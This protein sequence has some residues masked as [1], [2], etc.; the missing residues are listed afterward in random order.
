MNLIRPGLQELKEVRST[1]TVSAA[2]SRQLKQLHNELQVFL[3]TNLAPLESPVQT[4]FQDFYFTINGTE[5][6]TRFPEI[7]LST[8]VQFHDKL[9]ETTPQSEFDQLLIEFMHRIFVVIAAHE[10][11]NLM[12]SQTILYKDHLSYWSSMRMSTVSQ[13]IFGVQT[14][15]Q[16][17]A[18]LVSRAVEETVLGSS[19][20][21]FFRRL[22]QS[23][24]AVWQ[25]LCSMLKL[26]V[27]AL[28][29]NFVFRRSRL[30]WIR[31]PFTFI[32]RDIKHRIKTAQ[33][34]LDG[35]Y[36]KLGLLITSLPVDQGKLAAIVGSDNELSAVL[37]ASQP[38]RA[39]SAVPPPGFFTRNWPIIA[40]LVRFGPPTTTSVWQN[41]MAIV[42]W[43]RLNLVDT[44]VGFFKNW[45]VKPVWD[46]LGILRADDTMTITSKDSLRSD[47]E[48]LER[49]VMDFLR[50]NKVAATTEQV[51]Q[52]VS[53]GDL[54]MMMS[55]Y[56]NEIKTPYRL[57]V[58]GLMI[59]LLLIQIQKT[60]VD[61]ATAIS[62][63][64]KLLKLQQLLFGALSILPSLFI[65]YQANR[66][67]HRE[68]RDTEGKRLECLKSLSE[69][70]VLV[71]K[72]TAYD[73][74]N[75]L[76]R[77]FVGIVHLV[78][79]LRKAIPRGLRKEWLH[80]LNELMTVAVGNDDRAVRVLERIW[81][82]YAP[83]FR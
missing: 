23:A 66:A 33:K 76:G 78:L 8:V 28:D 34:Q 83:F 14:F 30:R 46:M 40:L 15:P 63:I 38:A 19:E 72:E 80:D 51:H 74:L 61:G 16:R 25:T 1:N 41:R 53:Q 6:L 57:L 69:I 59:R 32:D 49:M 50:D 39:H 5:K 12:I 64:D 75:G 3:E 47:L 17:L 70:S 68:S 2:L 11:A 24:S 65:L 7:L 52:A 79:L 13:V 82:V 27:A 35:Q 42:D 45:I 21:P 71:N 10:A 62:G 18:V 29:T 22:T 81:Y 44:A 60:K 4:I 77:L 73:R 37:R 20:L 58:N 48:S 26:G 43:I 36:E 56:E 31:L 54:T 9:T 55:Q 67:I